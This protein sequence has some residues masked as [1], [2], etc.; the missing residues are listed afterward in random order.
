MTQEIIDAVREIERE[1]GIG[2]ARSSRS[3]TRC[4]PRTRRRRAPRAPVELDGAGDFRVFSVELPT[5]VEERLLD[6]A[7]ERAS[8]SWSASRRRTASAR[9]CS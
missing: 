6:E 7:R 9:A 3:R 2:T 4:S 8:R 5:E 1:K